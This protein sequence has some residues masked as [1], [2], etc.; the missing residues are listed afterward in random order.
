MPQIWA[1]SRSKMSRRE[2]SKAVST[3][4]LGYMT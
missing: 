3:V 1:F 2:S 4:P